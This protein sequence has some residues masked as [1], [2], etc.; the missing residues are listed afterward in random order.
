M[1][2]PQP[3]DAIP[4]SGI[5]AGMTPAM[6]NSPREDYSRSQFSAAIGMRNGLIGGIAFWILAFLVYS[7]F[8]FFA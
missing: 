5:R 3:I 2:K 4:Q 1:S 6:F 8:R 7:V